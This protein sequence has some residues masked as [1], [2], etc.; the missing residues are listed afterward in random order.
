MGTRGPKKGSDG[1]KRVGEA[2]S[3]IHRKARKL[4][5]LAIRIE[6]GEVKPS[7]ELVEAVGDYLFGKVD[8]LQRLQAEVEQLRKQVAILEG[9]R[10]IDVSED[11]LREAVLKEVG[12]PV[13]GRAS[14]DPKRIDKDYKRER[15]QKDQ[16]GDRPTPEQRD[17][18]WENWPPPEPRGLV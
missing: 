16:E 14:R 8:E 5:R 7:R 1:A 11:D 18:F 10:G 17:E 6:R 3:E 12:G 9:R 2:K 13:I 15:A 4:D